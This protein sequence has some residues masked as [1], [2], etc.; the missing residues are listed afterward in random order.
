MSV[1]I[2]LMS[3]TSAWRSRFSHAK[4]AWVWLDFVFFGICTHCIASCFTALYRTALHDEDM[5]CMNNGSG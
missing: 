4:G 1:E 2:P 3:C 5:E